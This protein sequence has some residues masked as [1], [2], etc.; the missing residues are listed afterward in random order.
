MTISWGTFL[1]YYIDVYIDDGEKEI[2]NVYQ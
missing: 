1:S 2:D